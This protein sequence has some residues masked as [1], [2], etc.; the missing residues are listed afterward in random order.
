MLTDKK[1]GAFSVLYIFKEINGGKE[2]EWPHYYYRNGFMGLQ[3]NG[4]TINTSAATGLLEQD[5]QR[6]NF[7]AS[8]KSVC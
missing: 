5:S 7:S 8:D 4:V 1:E 2:N 3:S 6:L